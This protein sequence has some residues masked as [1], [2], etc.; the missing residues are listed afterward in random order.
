[1]CFLN[2]QCFLALLNREVQHLCDAKGAKCEEHNYRCQGQLAQL[3][4]RLHVVS[5]LIAFSHF[6]PLSSHLLLLDLPRPL[7]PFVSVS[8]HVALAPSINIAAPPSFHVLP[9]RHFFLRLGSVPASFPLICHTLQTL[10]LDLHLL[11]PSRISAS[12]STRSSFA[13]CICSLSIT[14]SAFCF[15]D[16]SVNIWTLANCNQ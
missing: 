11:K 6:S 5:P 9:L 3:G 15:K 13:F 7:K 1:M 10:H 14:G 4:A 12:P 8:I 16:V 2:N